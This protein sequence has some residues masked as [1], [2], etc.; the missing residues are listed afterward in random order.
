ML[1]R[2]S[3]FKLMRMLLPYIRGKIRIRTLSNP[4]LLCNCGEPCGQK[5]R[6]TLYSIATD[7][8]AIFREWLKIVQ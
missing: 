5:M 3:Q 8:T 2:F 1:K 7:I 6:L 4:L